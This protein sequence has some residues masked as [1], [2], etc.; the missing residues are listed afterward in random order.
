M[1]LP[2]AVLKRPSV[3]QMTTLGNV[4]NCTPHHVTLSF[5]ICVHSRSMT[6]Y[7]SMIVDLAV[8]ITRRQCEIRRWQND[9]IWVNSIASEKETCGTL[10]LHNASTFCRTHHSLDFGCES[11]KSLRDLDQ[12]VTCRDNNQNEIDQRFAW[13]LLAVYNRTTCLC[14]HCFSTLC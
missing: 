13:M 3:L 11:A 1:L 10:Y 7:N 5:G 12:N 14:Y 9:K 8:Y 6:T 4:R 2:Q